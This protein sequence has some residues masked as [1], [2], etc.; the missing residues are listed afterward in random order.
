[1]MQYRSDLL[2][3]CIGGT[4]PSGLRHQLRVYSRALA[5]RTLLAPDVGVAKKS[6]A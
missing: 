6:A 3:P 5:Q 2:E 4:L 1:M